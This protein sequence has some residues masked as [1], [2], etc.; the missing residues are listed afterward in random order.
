MTLSGAT[1]YGL[2]TRR[3]STLAPL[4]HSGREAM[5]LVKSEKEKFP[6]NFSKRGFVASSS[7]L[8]RTTWTR[9]PSFWD[10]SSTSSTIYSTI[11][12]LPRPIKAG[13][14]PMVEKRERLCCCTEILAILCV[15]IEGASWNFW[16]Q[17]IGMRRIIT[18]LRQRL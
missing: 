11:P 14:Y 13:S 17:V 3:G 8:P 10:L 15:S 5:P 4:C 2:Y 16:G 18:T 12:I 7:L 9:D 1:T 6:R